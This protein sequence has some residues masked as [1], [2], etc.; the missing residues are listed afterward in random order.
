MAKNINK[1]TVNYEK[2]T[3]EELEATLQDLGDKVRILRGMRHEAHLVWN[4]RI[5]EVRAREKV[6]AMSDKERAS[7]AQALGAKGI[8][9]KEG[10]GIPGA[11]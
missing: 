4:K 7:M 8:G 3:I 6:E 2:M 9:T 10:V 5:S 11:K 1:M